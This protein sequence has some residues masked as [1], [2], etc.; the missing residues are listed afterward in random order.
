MINVAESMGATAELQLPYTASYPVT[1]ND[2]ALTAEMAPILAAV[3]GPGRSFVRKPETGA[4]DFS[5][6][7]REVPGFYFILGGRPADILPEDTADHHT[8]DFYVDEAALTLG[9]RAMTAVTLEYM[10]LHPGE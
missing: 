10:R 4:E 5:F 6:I 8:P 9:V 1:Y 2:P 7:S 3:A